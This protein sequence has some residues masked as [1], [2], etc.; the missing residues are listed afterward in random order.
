MAD[1]QA[2]LKTLAHT[3]ERVA[4]AAD[5][6]GA[7]ASMTALLSECLACCAAGDITGAARAHLQDLQQRLTVWHDVWPRL[8]CD[9]QFRVAVAR[10]AHR[11]SAQLEQL[12]CRQLGGTKD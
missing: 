4:D 11:W 3:L 8:G 7:A 12:A 1:S 2:P 6:D 9:P 10:E 5:H